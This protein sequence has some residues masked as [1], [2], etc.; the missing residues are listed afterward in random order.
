MPS[1]FRAL[2]LTKRATRSVKNVNDRWSSRPVGSV[3]SSH[4]PDSLTAKTQSRSVSPRG[5]SARKMAASCLNARGEVRAAVASMVAR[6]NLI[7]NSPLA[8]GRSKSHALNVVACLWHV[9]ATARNASRRK[10]TTA[11]FPRLKKSQRAQR[12]RLG[13]NAFLWKIVSAPKTSSGGVS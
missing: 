11:P 6:T 12:P 9:D 8:N 4:A 1:A 13:L 2:R 3:N 10:T 5:R 7:V